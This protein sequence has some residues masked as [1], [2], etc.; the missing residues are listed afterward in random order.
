MKFKVHGYEKVLVI[1]TVEADSEEEAINKAWLQEYTEITD[2]VAAPG[3]PCDKKRWAVR[4]V[5]P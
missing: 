5:K 3:S 2:S 4:R 1:M